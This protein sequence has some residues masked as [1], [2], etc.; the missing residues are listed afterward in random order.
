MVDITINGMLIPKA[1][2]DGGSSV[3]LMTKETMELLGLN[4]LIPT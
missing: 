3:N 4:D 2:V 1:Q